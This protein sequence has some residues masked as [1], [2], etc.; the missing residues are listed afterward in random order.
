LIGTVV[1]TPPSFQKEIK[2]IRGETVKREKEE[3][4]DEAEAA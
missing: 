4:Q 2:N 3:T 1:H